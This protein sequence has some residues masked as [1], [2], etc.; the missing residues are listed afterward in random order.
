[1]LVRLN[2]E[3]LFCSVNN[4]R[5]LVFIFFIL[6]SILNVFW[7]IFPIQLKKKQHYQNRHIFTFFVILFN[8]YLILDT[9]SYKHFRH[10]FFSQL[11]SKFP[12]GL[13]PF[14]MWQQCVWHKMK[15]SWKRNIGV[16]QLIFLEYW[17]SSCSH[18]QS[19]RSCL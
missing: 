2:V 9:F 15:Q 6:L 13:A 3:S 12:A 10:T 19:S 17:S 16:E 5:L 14:S 11:L 8:N 1:M 7:N 18:S 4:L